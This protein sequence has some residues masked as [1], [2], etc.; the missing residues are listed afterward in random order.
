MKK[1][2]VLDLL[3][4]V[5]ILALGYQLYQVQQRV[6]RLETV[7]RGAG[8]ALDAASLLPMPALTPAGQRVTIDRG[9]PRL[10]FY[11]SPH[12][13]YCGKNMPVWSEVTH[14]IGAS[15]ALFLVGDEREMPQMPAYLAQYAAGTVPALAADQ[16]VLGRYYMLQVPKTVLVSADGK[17]E[18]VWRGA[19]TTE[20]VLQAWT[21]VLHR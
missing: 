20:A 3:S 7:T 4:L 10:I 12:C 13:G 2:P 6:T 19:V 18:K 9:E 5:V 14:R 15:H 21:S 8:D 11:M 1:L 16:E 17:V